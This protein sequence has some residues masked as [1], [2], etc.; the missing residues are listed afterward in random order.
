MRIA[1][2]IAKPLSLVIR[3]VEDQPFSILIYAGLPSA[4]RFIYYNSPH[5]NVPAARR[6]ALLTLPPFLFV[7]HRTRARVERVG[8]DETNP[9]YVFWAEFL[10]DNYEEWLSEDIGFVYRPKRRPPA[11]T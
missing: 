9:D 8:S 7:T 5:P 10:R 4:T 3:S 2:G 11:G 6:A 1:E